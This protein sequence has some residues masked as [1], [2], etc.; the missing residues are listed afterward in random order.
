MNSYEHGGLNVLDFDTL[1][2]TFKINWA[3]QFLTNPVSIWNFIPNFTFS[4]FGG[5]SFILGCNYNVNKIPEKLSLFPKQVLLAWFLIH[6]K[7]QLFSP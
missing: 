7:A 3:K 4:R 5:L 1:N 2:N 6:S